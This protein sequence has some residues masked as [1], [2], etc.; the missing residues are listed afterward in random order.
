MF[1]EFGKA[2]VPGDLIDRGNK[3]S[4]GWRDGEQEL[5]GICL[6]ITQKHRSGKYKLTRILGIG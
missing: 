3:W 5:R 6:Q 1:T 2:E 4:W